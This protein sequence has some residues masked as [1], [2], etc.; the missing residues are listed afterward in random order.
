M[1][2]IQKTQEA[3]SICPNSKD[4]KHNYDN[5][6]DP[7]GNYCRNCDW[8]EKYDE[9][10]NK[11]EHKALSTQLSTYREALGAA[12]DDITPIVSWAKAYP[13]DVF[14]EPTQ[15]EWAKANQVLKDA[16]LSLT[17]ISGSN[18]RHV[19]TEISKMASDALSKI[20]SALTEGK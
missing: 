15:E 18:M 13:L 16:G 9:Y 11:D 5:F 20:E 1:D 19:I 10:C 14:I 7:F 8:K 12:A 17:A 2:D 3:E 6:D 4:G